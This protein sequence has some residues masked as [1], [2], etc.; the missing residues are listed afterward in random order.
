MRKVTFG[1]FLLQS[2][3]I[4]EDYLYVFGGTTGW[5]Y[6]ADLHRMHI[7]DHTW[8]LIKPQG[9]VPEGRYVSHMDLNQT[10]RGCA[11]G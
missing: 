8:T 9:D 1:L 3:I 6:N 10:S 5:I 7:K 2:M 11:R 4:V